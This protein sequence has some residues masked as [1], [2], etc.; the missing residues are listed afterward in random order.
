M[1]TGILLQNI[2]VALILAGSLLFT[3][4]KIY[5]SVQPKKNPGCSSGCTDC[6]LKQ[7]CSDARENIQ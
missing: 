1:T 5:K 2:I 6:P 7:P 3:A 4:I